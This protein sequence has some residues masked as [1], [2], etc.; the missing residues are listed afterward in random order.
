MQEGNITPVTREWFVGMHRDPPVID[1]VQTSPDLARRHQI[2][3]SGA[4]T[5]HLPA[6][7]QHRMACGGRH[8]PST[9]A[10]DDIP[11]IVS[12]LQPIIMYLLALPFPGEHERQKWY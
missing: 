9:A 11:V 3:G 4:A 6:E 7:C 10:S 2:V 12:S 5:R 8:Q 1:L